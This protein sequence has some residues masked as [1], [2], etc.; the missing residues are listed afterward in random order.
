[1]LLRR[2]YSLKPARTS[3]N[4]TFA[5]KYPKVYKPAKTAASSKRRPSKLLTRVPAE[6]RLA[7]VKP[8]F[9]PLNSTT[10]KAKVSKPSVKTLSGKQT[11]S[12]VSETWQAIRDSH[13]KEFQLVKPENRDASD[14]KTF[15]S[16]SLNP[17]LV[18]GI[19][20][21]LGFKTPSVVQQTC[22]SEVIANPETH[23]LVGSQT[24]SGKTVAYLA[25]IMHFLKE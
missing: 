20:T 12:T 2:F 3:S 13:N 22:I 5:T 21:G 1:M 15:E 19:Q 10:V 17:S 16:M 8:A 14:F 18:E 25:P 24:G 4:F 23:F 6:H 11:E 7:A 9:K